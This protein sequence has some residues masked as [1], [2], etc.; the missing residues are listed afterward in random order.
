MTSVNK[1][2]NKSNNQNDITIMQ[3]EI[4]RLRSI[5]F[6]LQYTLF[7]LQ[8]NFNRLLDHINGPLPVLPPYSPNM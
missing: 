5:T 3:K 8:H 7:N 1:S 4:E 6:D 2:E